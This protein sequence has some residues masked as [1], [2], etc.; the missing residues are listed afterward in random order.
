MF[1]RAALVIAICLLAV[2]TW[3][4]R[5]P[6]PQAQQALPVQAHE[7]IVLH[8][9]EGAYRDLLVYDPSYDG[10]RFVTQADGRAV[11]SSGRFVVTASGQTV[12]YPSPEPRWEI[13]F[14]TEEPDGPRT[15]L[16]PFGT[17]WIAWKTI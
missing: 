9:T 3:N 15:D 17:Y 5:T 10:F 7:T 16:V 4:F 14:Y 6:L 1:P 13:T 11:D 8:R 2:L 12:G